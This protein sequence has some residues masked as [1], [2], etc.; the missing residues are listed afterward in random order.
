MKLITKRQS[1][2]LQALLSGEVTDYHIGR[3]L[4]YI[5]VY[6][7]YQGV[8]SIPIKKILIGDDISYAI[9]CAEEIMDKLTEGE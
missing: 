1:K 8:V 9:R 5:I 4:A 6:A 2:A 7:E 3:S